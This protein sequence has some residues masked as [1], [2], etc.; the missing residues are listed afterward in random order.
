MP[1]QNHLVN[2]YLYFQEYIVINNFIL[3]GG[4]EG[5]IILPPDFDTS[6]GVAIFGTPR[7]WPNRMVP[8]D[9]SA[10]TSNV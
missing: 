5:D 10:I 9:I 8:Y 7:R 6:R 3:G 2:T 1:I 4:F